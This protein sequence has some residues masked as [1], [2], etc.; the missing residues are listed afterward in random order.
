MTPDLDTVKRRHGLVG[1]NPAYLRALRMALQ[2]APVDLS[3]LVLGENG[4]GKDIFPR[5]IHEYSRRRDREYVPVNCGA[6]PEGTIDSELFGHV[7]GAFTGADRDRKG[8]FETADKGLIFLDEIGEL[9]LATQSKLLR[10]L[11]AGEIMRMGSSEVQKVDVRVVAAT[12]VDLAQA[13]AEHR[14]REDLFYRLNGLSIQVPPLRKRLE[15]LPALFHTFAAN[16]ADRQNMPQ[17]LLSGEARDRLL[18]YDW[19]GNIRQLKNFAEQCTVLHPG[20]TLSVDDIS[21]LLPLTN[22][23]STATTTMP[24]PASP[25]GTL[26]GGQWEMVMQTLAKLRADVSELQG[27]VKELQGQRSK[28]TQSIVDVE[29]VDDDTAPVRPMERALTLEEAEKNTIVEALRRNDYNKRRTAKELNISERTLYRKIETY[30]LDE[31]K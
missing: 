30:G 31:K 19:P 21:S 3:V 23:P 14:F 9:P 7:K 5:I 16:F 10:V 20:A 27:Q 8:Y 18:T 6:I 15:D 13:V 29:T 12:N 25:A 28:P 2:V 17:A 26:Y 11:E 24:V 22:A 4:S 1:T